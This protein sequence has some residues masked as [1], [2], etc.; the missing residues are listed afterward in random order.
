[1][2]CFGRNAS[3]V[4]ALVVASAG[5]LS[6]FADAARVA[7]QT[8]EAY[9]YQQITNITDSYTGSVGFPVPSADGT[10]T[11]FADAPGSG[12]PASPNRIFRMASDGSGLAEVDS[13]VPK[14]FCGSWVDLSAD[15]GVVVSTESIQLRVTTG[16]TGTTI[17]EFAS[18]EVSSIRLT[19]GGDRIGFILARDTALAGSSEALPSG[20]YL[21]NGDG[22]DLRLVAG[23]EQIAAAAGL[24]ADQIAML[25]LASQALDLS[26]DGSKLVF[27]S[28]VGPEQWVF[29]VNA[30]GSGLTQLRTGTTWVQRVAISG[31]GATV[32]MDV[33]PTGTDLNEIAIVPATGGTPTVLASATNS[34]TSDPIQLTTDGGK[35][36]V[37][38]NS[39]LIDTASGQIDLLAVSIEGLGGTHLAVIPDGLPR[40]TMDATATK[41]LYVM[42]SVRC[43]DCAN[44]SEQLAVMTFA[45]AP[46]NAPIVSNPAIEPRSIPLDDPT[47]TLTVSAQVSA[48]VGEL[49]GIGF[50]GVL[51]TGAVDANFGSTTLLSE[52]TTLSDPA[53]GS[54]VYT[55]ADVPYVQRSTAEPGPREMR[56][57]AEVE[58]ADGYRYGT[59]VDAGVVELT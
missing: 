48:P 38:P 39:L 10:M 36:L 29:S 7:A 59:A 37:S 28:W 17:L 41:L 23:A 52:A 50:A 42:R 13:Y 16:G 47:Q 14:C 9:Y 56:I 33:V 34:G 18:N 24:T 32:A 8:S 40:A 44:L 25:R 12:D 31:D 26:D 53:G 43:A 57:A 55:Q 21:V 3:L 22:S 4:V 49:L 5:A 20:I 35:L 30:D 54:G 2:R 45:N 11:A 46:A 58:T 15:G 27:G 19:A 51:P 6:G 1:M